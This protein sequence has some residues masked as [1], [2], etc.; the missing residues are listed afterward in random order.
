MMASMQLSGDEYLDYLEW[1][2]SNPVVP[3]GKTTIETFKTFRMGQM[4]IKDYD[5]R[6]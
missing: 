5:K 2:R 1:I 3:A 4:R 6:D